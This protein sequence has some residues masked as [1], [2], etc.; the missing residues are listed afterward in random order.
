MCTIG[1]GFGLSH[2]PAVVMLSLYFDTKIG[3]ATGIAMSGTGLG[4]IFMSVVT[5]YLVDEYGW[6][7]TMLVLSAINANLCVAAA[8]MRP[9]MKLR[10]HRVSNDD[11]K[12]EAAVEVASVEKTDHI[13]NK[14][15]QIPPTDPSCK[16]I[17]ITVNP[18]QE[19]SKDASPARTHINHT[20]AHDAL[21]THEIKARS[22]G[23]SQVSA[24]GLNGAAAR[25]GA[26]GTIIVVYD[27]AIEAEVESA[28]R[29]CCFVDLICRPVIRFF[30]SVY[31]F[32]I[33]KNPFYLS[34]LMGIN[35]N[36]FGMTIVSAHTV[37]TKQNLI[38]KNFM[39]CNYLVVTSRAK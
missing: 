1:I 10:K 11:V 25:N 39:T 3:T 32:E 30:D 15:M 16:Q 19:K 31:G 24:D 22:N 14:Y 9:V 6:R 2:L 36:F 33:W 7:G 38:T 23:Y 20:D 8:T 34:F 13:G 4:T 17:K 21:R 12:D 18:V 28:K 26:N 35:L 37:R 5:Q 29:S 27:K